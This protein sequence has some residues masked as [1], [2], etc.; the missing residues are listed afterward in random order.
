MSGAKVSKQNTPTVRIFSKIFFHPG[1]DFLGKPIS[2][3]RF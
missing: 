3:R 2:L 1:F